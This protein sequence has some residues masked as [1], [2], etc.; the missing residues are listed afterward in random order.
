MGFFELTP[1]GVY[2]VEMGPKNGQIGDPIEVFRE[3]LSTVLSMRQGVTPATA[4]ALRG[5]TPLLMG[6]WT[7]VGRSA[8]TTALSEYQTSVAGTPYSPLRNNSNMFVNSIFKR[9]GADPNVPGAF[10]PAY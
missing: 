1:D 9:I 7:Q 2:V 5:E 10:A 3:R 6:N 8:L 4:A